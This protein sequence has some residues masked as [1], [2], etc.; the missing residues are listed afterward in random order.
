MRK[1]SPL[2]GVV[3]VLCLA[4]VSAQA[5]P[6]IGTFT[7]NTLPANDDSSTGLV[8]LGFGFNFFGTT[9]TGTYVN[10]NGNITFIGPLSTFT[11]FGLTGAVPQPIIAPF[12]ADVD[13]RAGN[14]VQYGT[15][16]FGGQAAFGV[17]WPGVGYYDAHADKLNTFELVL[18]DRSDIAA[19]DADF[20]FNYGDI[21]WETGDASGGVNGFG[22]SCAAFGYSNGSGLPGTFFEGP[23]SHVCGALI[24]GGPNELV[25]ATNDGVPGQFRFQVRGGEVVPPVGVPEPGSLLLLGM[26]LLALTGM[27]RRRPRV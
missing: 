23:G 5:S 8:P 20:Y 11:P 12:F 4:A 27:P 13:T 26:G 24:N 10:T 17:E 7:G 6:I 9:Y 21:L 18:V 19:G 2:L 14:L 15:G 16:T 3:S 22:G 25:S 1:L